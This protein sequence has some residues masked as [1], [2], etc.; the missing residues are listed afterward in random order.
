[1]NEIEIL[2][3][4]QRLEARKDGHTIAF[5]CH[6]GQVASYKKRVEPE[7][8]AQ[9]SVRDG[10]ATAE[11]RTV[12]PSTTHARPRLLDGGVIAYPK[13]GWEPPPV[14]DGYQR[15]SQNLQSPDAWIFIPI[16]PACDQRTRNITYSACGAAQ[17]TYRCEQHGEIPIERCQSCREIDS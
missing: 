9:C 8:C 12:N 11:K 5:I 1:M 15:K 6:N 4:T 16:L 17:V 7:T 13:R 14:P 3:C 2:P 10:S